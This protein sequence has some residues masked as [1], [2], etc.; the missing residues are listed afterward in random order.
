[1]LRRL[2]APNESKTEGERSAIGMS[3]TRRERLCR[4][5]SRQKLGDEREDKR[6]K[7][8]HTHEVRHAKQIGKGGI[9]HQPLGGTGRLDAFHN[10]APGMTKRRGNP[11]LE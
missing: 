11:W 9:W 10:T 7:I 8:T 5:Q 1:M 6:K 4:L 3:A 2:E